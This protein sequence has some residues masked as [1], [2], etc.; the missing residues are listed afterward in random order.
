[1]GF[2]SPSLSPLC[3]RPLGAHS[4]GSSPDQPETAA[5]T[6]DVD[7]TL[8]DKNTINQHSSKPAVDTPTEDESGAGCGVCLIKPWTKAGLIGSESYDYKYLCKPALLPWCIK[9][10][11]PPPYFFGKDAKLPLTLSLFLGL[12]LLPFSVVRA[13]GRRGASS[14][15]AN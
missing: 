8:D 6:A 12:S 5:D 2:R 15:R 14:I 7:A 3:A 4:S 1:M 9:G 13:Q 11:A 10:G